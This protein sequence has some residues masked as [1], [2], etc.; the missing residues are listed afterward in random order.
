MCINI[1]SIS[2]TYK[3]EQSLE[4]HWSFITDRSLATLDLLSGRNQHQHLQAPCTVAMGKP[5]EPLTSATTLL[6]R[7]LSNKAA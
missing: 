6:A 2:N 1:Y 4:S 5:K 3:P 7:L